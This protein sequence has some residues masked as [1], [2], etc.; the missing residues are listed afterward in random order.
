M[1]EKELNDPRLQAMLKRFKHNILSIFK[2]SQN[3]NELPKRT[4]R[5]NGN[6]YHIF[7]SNNFRDVLNIN[8]HKSSTDMTLNNF[9]LIISACWNENFQPITN[10][11]TKDKYTGRYRLGIYSM[12]DPGSSPF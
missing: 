11:M 12:F 3:Y 8:Q 1:N 7:K 9:K 5:A 2:I 4:M 10:D 6:I